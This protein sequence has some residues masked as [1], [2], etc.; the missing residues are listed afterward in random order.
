MNVK[1]IVDSLTL[2]EKA[3]LLTGGSSMGTFPIERFGVEVQEIADGPHGVRFNDKHGNCTMFPALCTLASAWDPEI[4]EKM[5]EGIAND[6]VEHGISMILG[7]GINIKKNILCG[8]NFEYLSE[9]PVLAGKMAAGYVRGL[10]KKGVGACVKHYAANNQELYRV[11]A[12]SELDERTLREIYLKAFEIVVKESNPAAVMCAYNKVNSVYCSENRFLLTEVLK[13]EWD[14]KGLVISDWGAV[15]N[16]CRSVMAGLDLEMP[17][18]PA[19]VEQIKAGLE[20][21][22]ITMQAIDKAASNVLNYVMNVD[23]KKQKYDREKQHKM[24]VDIAA[25]GTVLLKN[26]KKT[27]P[28][29]SAKYK[30]IAVVGEFAIRPLVGGQGS[31]EVFPDEKC[32]DNPLEELKKRLP[33]TEFKYMEFYQ[34]YSFSKNMLW[35]KEDEFLN[36]TQDVD[37]I[38][39]FAGSMGSEDTEKFDRRSAQLNPNYELFIEMAVSHGRECMVVLQNGGALIL[40]DWVEHDTVGAIVES[41][42]GGEGTGSAIADV[43]C[44]KTNPS[45]KLPETFPRVMRRDIEYPGTAQKVIYD[46]KLNVGY[47]YYDKHTDEILYPFGHGLSY[48]EFEYKNVNVALENEK[49]IVSL[50]LKNVGDN[51][52]AEVVQIY[53]GDPNS[54]MTKPMKELKA[55][56]KIFV[57]KGE[58]ANVEIAIPVADIAYYNTMLH[59]WVVEN[60]RYDIYVGSS[61]QDIRSVVSFMYAGDMPYTMEAIHES[62]IGDNSGSKQ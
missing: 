20:D 32:I 18:N 37:L 14:Y 49:I 33:D 3:L 10:Q 7:P 51:D 48:T 31:A 5:G 1:E 43:L 55:F 12:S 8:R 2:E 52:G 45:G 44:G 47:R 11:K 36:F 19:I 9:D 27:L 41:W 42:L 30:K 17:Q 59:S 34:I 40:G 28:L 29:T 38:V 23:I 39:F 21:G 22:R 46:E 6:C 35:P 57:H 56:K 50:K 54:T 24:A 61:S 60:G 62:M 25:A 53:V 16:I 13:E 26:K 4:G 15:H 58:T